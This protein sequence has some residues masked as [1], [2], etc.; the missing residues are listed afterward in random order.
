MVGCTKTVYLPKDAGYY[1]DLYL[2]TLN[3]KLECEELLD[4]CAEA[5]ENIRRET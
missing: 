3:Q 4:E 1:Y 2:D 5:G